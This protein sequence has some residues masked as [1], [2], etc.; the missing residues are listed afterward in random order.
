[1]FLLQSTF[2]RLVAMLV[3]ICIVWTFAACVMICTAHASETQRQ[4]G[5]WSSSE[6]EFS[7][8]TECCP[9]GTSQV[10]VLPDRR[11]LARKVHN[12]HSAFYA[13]PV[14]LQPPLLS[15]YAHTSLGPIFA[16][17]PIERTCALRI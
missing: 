12:N 2:K 1:M 7:E 17:P 16:D 15:P 9:I 6:R 5:I 8:A 11:S 4:H 13:Q 3:P 10:S 14:E